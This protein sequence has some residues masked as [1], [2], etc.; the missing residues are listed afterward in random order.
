MCHSLVNKEVFSHK[1]DFMILGLFQTNSFYDSA[2][3]G[4]PGPTGP[5]FLQGLFCPEISF[6]LGVSVEGGVR[7]PSLLLSTQ[8]YLDLC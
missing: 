1:L 3:G 6:L 8:A 2:L 5:R 7:S 4:L